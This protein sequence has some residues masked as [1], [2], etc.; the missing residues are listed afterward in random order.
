MNYLDIQTTSQTTA[1]G[2]VWEQERRI[3]ILV[4]RIE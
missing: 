4:L 1:L 3:D 2:D